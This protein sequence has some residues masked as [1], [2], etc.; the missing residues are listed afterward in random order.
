MQAV[1]AVQDYVRTTAPRGRETERVGPFLATFTPGTS[2]PM[3][4]YAI[5][6]TS[7]QPSAAQIAELTEAFQRRGLLPRLEYFPEVAP[8]L[9]QSLVTAGYTLERRIPLMVCAPDDRVD[10]PPP[11]SIAI[12]PPACDDDIRQ[13]RSAQ[14]TAFGES[15]DVT[16][17]DVEQAKAATDRGGIAALA[18]DLTTGQVVGGGL[19]LELVNGTTEIGGIGVLDT[20][21][22]RG[23][24]AAITAWLTREAHQRDAHTAFLTAGD[25]GAARVYTRVGYRPSGVCVHLALT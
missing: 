24:A 10:A 8:D 17:D 12:R 20:H 18:A 16:D 21:R 13:M 23:V 14:N 2:H 25:N 15:P 1:F 19:A 3:V 4:N 6:D 11:H 9:E 7:A 22:R 5:P